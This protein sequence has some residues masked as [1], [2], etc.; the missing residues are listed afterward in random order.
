VTSTPRTVCCR[1][2]QALLA[3]GRGGYDTTR[4]LTDEMKKWAAPRTART[5]QMNA[6]QARA[7]LR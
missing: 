7:L 6:W 2:V 1:H 4:A 5:T 3:A